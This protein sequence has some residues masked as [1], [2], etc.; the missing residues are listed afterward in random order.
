MKKEYIKPK[1]INLSETINEDDIIRTTNSFCRATAE[2]ISDIFSMW[3]NPDT[4]KRF[5][6]T[7]LVT[8]S[9]DLERYAEYLSTNPDKYIS[10]KQLYT[11][12]RGLTEEESDELRPNANEP[13]LFPATRMQTNIDE[14]ILKTENTIG[15]ETCID[16]IKKI[17]W[18]YDCITLI[19]PRIRNRNW[20]YIN[21]HDNID[22]YWFSSLITNIR[23]W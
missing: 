12:S 18:I 16:D 13:R 11:K 1:P 4:K 5:D 23:N 17:D 3:I 7:E 22:N 19:K 8:I 6:Y 15:I 20:E 21:N 10:E 9:L 14:F 2:E